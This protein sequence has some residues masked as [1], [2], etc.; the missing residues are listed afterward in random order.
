MHGTN[1]FRRVATEII[2]AFGNARGHEL[3]APPANDELPHE[4]GLRFHARVE[5]LLEVDAH[6]LALALVKPLESVDGDGGDEIV[7]FKKVDVLPAELQCA[8]V[9]RI[10][11]DARDKIVVDDEFSMLG[12]R[13]LDGISALDKVRRDVLLRRTFE[14]EAEYV[15]D[16][17]VVLAVGQQEMCGAPVISVFGVASCPL[18]FGGLAIDGVR[19]IERMLVNVLFRHDERDAEQHLTRRLVREH[20]PVGELEVFDVALVEHIDYLA[21]LLHVAR[22]AVWRPRED[23]VERASADGLQH[24]AE[25][26]APV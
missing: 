9:E 26:R 25:L 8:N 20:E 15:P 7:F 3:P 5:Y 16:E 22:K 14:A 1:F 10:M 6:F 21:R 19:D 13:R 24:G 11:E 17:L 2:L 12:V 4:R 18:A 23:G